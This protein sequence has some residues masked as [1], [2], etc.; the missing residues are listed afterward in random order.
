VSLKK[1]EHKRDLARDTRDAQ[2]AACLAAPDPALCG[3]QARAAFRAEMDRLDVKEA[4]ER[5]KT[6]RKLDDLRVQRSSCT[7]EVAPRADSRDRACPKFP[8]R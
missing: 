2:L 4:E 1:I 3:Q 6:R 7:Y 8:A 5:E